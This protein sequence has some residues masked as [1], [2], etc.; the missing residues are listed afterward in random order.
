MIAVLGTRFANSLVSEMHGSGHEGSGS[1]SRG[2]RCCKYVCK[3]LAD[4]EITILINNAGGPPRI[5]SE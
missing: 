5:S 2:F 4:R 3:S 1:R